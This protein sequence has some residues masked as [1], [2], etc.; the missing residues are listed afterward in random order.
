MIKAMIRAAGP[1]AWV[2]SGVV[3]IAGA[4]EAP[5]L[6]H[7]M[8]RPT[9]HPAP[10]GPAAIYTDPSGTS[11]WTKLAHPAPFNAGAMLQLTDGTVLVQDQGTQNNGSGNWW[12][13]TPDVT[14]S[15]VHGTWSQLASLPADYAPLYFAS[16]VLPDGRVIIQ[17]GEYN[18]GAEAWTNLGAIYDPVANAWTPVQPPDAGEG[19]WV[20]IGDGPSTVLANG[21]FML[22]ASGYSGTKAEAILTA[23]KLT[24]TTTGA[25]KADG[26]GEE[27][28]SLLPN[29]DVL[30]VDTT[31]TDPSQNTEIYSPKTGTW[32]S[33]GKTPVP[34]IDSVGEVGPQVLLPNGSV[35]AVGSTPNTAL[36]SSKSG[37]WTAGPSFPA[38]GGAEYD[39]ADGAAAVLPDGE[40]LIDVSPGVYQ[41]P[42]H[43][44]QFDGKK[45]T[46]VADAPNATQLSS[47]DGFMMMLPTGEVMF[48]DR[49]GDITVYSNG[50]PP[51][52]AWRPT[53]ESVPTALTAGDSYKLEG[54]Q[55]NGLT[56][57]AAYG[58][59]Y[60]SA[61][62]FPLVR[63]TIT[64]SGHVFYAR[65]YGMS[66]MSVAPQHASS[67]NFEIPKGIQTG[68]A[69]LQVVA[70]GIASEPV[71]VTVKAPV[72]SPHG[73]NPP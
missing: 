3:S 15:Y 8:G 34:L 6:P 19:E 73:E 2:L 61:T 27:G 21:E 64:A 26:N 32:A 44:F 59:D 40:V 35:F 29:G 48:N 38:I 37:K 31:D 43:F 46:Q 13:L 5:P 58:D 55:L 9:P 7:A 42:T 63:L 62:N 1:S 68:A 30:T 45:L 69:V 10:A 51:L 28:W 71:D 17:G 52:A 49:I 57:D 47:Y 11:P 36:Y 72:A 60:Q 14:G 70:N 33:A 25:G 16:A 20:R 18:F 41:T 12:K 22:G 65:T 39:S 24:W 4:V 53:I 56:Q 54:L 67:V 66:S 23:S 50:K